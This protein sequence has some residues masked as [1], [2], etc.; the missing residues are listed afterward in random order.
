MSYSARALGDRALDHAPVQHQADAEP[1][2][3]LVEPRLVEGVAVAEPPAIEGRDRL[4]VGLEDEQAQPAALQRRW[5]RNPR[6]R[7]GR[8][9]AASEEPPRSPSARNE[10]GR[11]S[12][13][14]RSSSS[15][16]L[17]LAQLDR[18]LALEPAVEAPQLLAKARRAARR[19]SRRSSSRRSDAKGSTEARALAASQQPAPARRGARPRDQAASASTLSS[20]SAL[21]RRAVAT[22]RGDRAARR[23]PP[24][25]PARRRDAG[26]RRGWRPRSCT[27]RGNPRRSIAKGIRPSECAVAVA[28][29]RHPDLAPCRR[30][31]AAR[32]S[33]HSGETKALP[34][35]SASSRQRR[36]VRRAPRRP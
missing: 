32:H 30:S 4:A 3:S 18:R 27:A 1:A 19:G 36:R 23:P 25:R 16:S 33:N 26:S 7:R 14:S 12:P 11:R 10:G 5:R 13:R 17:G 34:R 15:G 2:P 35:R 9:A 20:T 24:R 31:A 28:D 29:D 21:Q 8:F 22:E 6:G